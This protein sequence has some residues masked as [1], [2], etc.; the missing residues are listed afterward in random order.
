ML[1]SVIILNYNTY[2]LTCNCIESVI[3]YTRG[4]TYEIILVD[5]N[6]TE[7]DAS[8]FS[9][10]FPGIT[11]IKNKE[12]NGFA[13]GNNLGIQYAQ[14]D[15][16]L[17]LNS[18]TLLQEDAISRAAFTLAQNSSIGALGVKMTYPDG[19]LQYTARRFRSVQ[20]ELLDLLRFVLLLMAYKKR[21]LLML[22]KYFKCDFNTT[23]DW[24]N[25]AF[26]MLPRKI[27]LQMPGHKL[28][29]RFFMYG[30]DHLWCYQIKKL[31]YNCFFYCETA[32]IHLNNGSTDRR[33]QLLLSKTMMRNEL[34]IMRVIYKRGLYY[35]F[36]RTIY[37]SKEYCRYC[38]KWLVFVVFNRQIR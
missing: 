22:G 2:Q 33:K 12:N 1:V 4:V 6:S 25:G 16:I 5:N 31:G 32:I 8:L 19:S 17:L 14:G 15:T 7:C 30:E 35:Y 36:L 13:K 23:C 20:W 27:I 26:F 21:A 28:D 34:E 29:D 9:E 18:D 37:I 24:L 38:I 10:K 11:L 3:K